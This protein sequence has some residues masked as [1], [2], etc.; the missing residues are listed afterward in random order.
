M[1]YATDTSAIGCRCSPNCSPLQGRSLV[2]CPMGKAWKRYTAMATRKN[3]A[4]YWGVAHHFELVTGSG[5]KE[6]LV[7]SGDAQWGTTHLELYMKAILNTVGERSST[8]TFQNQPNRA[9]ALK[10]MPLCGICHMYHTKGFQ[11]KCTLALGCIHSYTAA[12]WPPC[13]SRSCPATLV[14]PR[15]Q[16]ADL[17]IPFTHYPPPPSPPMLG[18]RARRGTGNTGS[19]PPIPIKAE[20]L[21]WQLTWYSHKT[22]LIASFFFGFDVGYIGSSPHSRPH[23]LKSVLEPSHIVQQKFSAE[24]AKRHTAGPF[25]TQPFPHMQPS[26][27]GLL[28]KKVPGTFR[29]IHHLSYQIILKTNQWTMISLMLG[30]LFII[31]Q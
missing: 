7:A 10:I 13:P 18:T 9:P 21:G 11:H 1:L 14:T 3:S 17:A 28:E 8:S 6:K 26:L 4:M 19:N 25:T 24:L 15:T 12:F 30:L 22:L 29:M 23:N 31:E 27:L 5:W 16:E 2:H 20:G